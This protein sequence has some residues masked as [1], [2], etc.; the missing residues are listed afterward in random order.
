MKCSPVGTRACGR[1]FAMPGALNKQRM[2]VSLTE[3]LIVIVVIGILA[4]IALPL[5][6][7]V[8]ES[9][10]EAV[11]QETMER[12]NRAVNG[13]RMSAGPLTTNADSEMAVFTALTTRDETIAGTP[14][15]STKEDL[16]FSSDVQTYRF[17]WNGTYFELLR[18]GTAGSGL[19]L[20]GN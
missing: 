18:P 6:T 3:L 15:Y 17:S 9:A 13:H 12:L 20:P 19:T 4:L 8:P 11:A 16:E 10:R 7:N 1:N 14:F 5:I 2:G